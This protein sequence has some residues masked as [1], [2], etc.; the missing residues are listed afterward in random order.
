M[1]YKSRKWTTGSERESERRKA[2]KMKNL[3]C[4]NQSVCVN[5]GKTVL[6][7]DNKKKHNRIYRGEFSLC[8]ATLPGQVDRTEQLKAVLFLS[9]RHLLIKRKFRVTLERKRERERTIIRWL[10]DFCFV[11]ELFK[12]KTFASKTFR[13]HSHTHRMS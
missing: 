4:K 12:H 11:C 5:T 10:L 2:D 8:F 13:D 7:F 1:Y 9:V 6:K 3:K